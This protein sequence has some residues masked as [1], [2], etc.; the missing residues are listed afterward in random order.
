M[1]ASNTIEI[2]GKLYDA[3]TGKPIGSDEK[4]IVKDAVKKRTKKMAAATGTIDGFRAAKKP[5][6]KVVVSDKKA[7]RSTLNSMKRGPK[8]S[9]TLHRGIVQQPAKAMPTAATKVAQPPKVQSTALKAAKNPAYERAQK[10]EKS[11]LISRFGAPVQKQTIQTEKK[12]TD[13]KPVKNTAP[14]PNSEPKKETPLQ[15]ALTHAASSPPPKQKAAKRPRKKAK[16]AGIGSAVLA[17][18]LLAAYVAYLNIPSIS[19]RV[20][21]HQAG[22]AATLPGYRPTGY[23]FRGPIEYHP[24]QVTINFQAAN[25]VK[26]FSLSQQETTWDSTALLENYVAKHTAQYVTYQDRGLTIYIYD[27]SNASWVN[28]GKMYTIN[29][30]NTQLDTDQILKLAT[31]M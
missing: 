5:V 11:P 2:N 7:S 15:T 6:K 24:G 10:I 25:G 17:G 26:M 19:M 16:L 20:A 29:A 23:S 4:N 8:Q 13:E 28:G 30:E 21:A 22:F 1:G 14:Q 12:Q 9:V 31:S 3:R 18:C 27:G